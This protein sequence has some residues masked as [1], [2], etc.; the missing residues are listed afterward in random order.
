[1]QGASFWDAWRRHFYA[2]ERY[3]IAG[4][5]PRGRWGMRCIEAQYERVHAIRGFGVGTAGRPRG[6]GKRRI[7]RAQGKF[8]EAGEAGFYRG[9][10]YRQ[11]KVDGRL[12]NAEATDSRIRLVHCAPGPAGNSARGGRGHEFFHRKLSSAVFAG[13]MR[14]GWIGAL[15]GRKEKAGGR[16]DALGRDFAGDCAE[17]RCGKSSDGGAREAFYARALQDLS[18][19]RRGALAFVW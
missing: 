4:N 11:G 12:G 3:L 6:G 19:W 13:G 17:R 9:Q 18:R 15:P 8:V 14:S 7:F 10:I 16:G 2:G 1:M 5:F